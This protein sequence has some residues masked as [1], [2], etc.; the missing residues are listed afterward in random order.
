MSICEHY[1][2]K[3]TRIRLLKQRNLGPSVARNK[4]ID[5]AKGKYIA[6]VD[7]DD[8]VEKDMYSILYCNA[9][10][11]N[12]DIVICGFTRDWPDGKIEENVINFKNEEVIT[13]DI[14]ILKY[15]SKYWMGLKYANYIC[16]KLYSRNLFF[17]H[18]VRFPDDLRFGEDRILHYILLPYINKTIYINRDLYHYVQRLDSAV[19][20]RGNQQNLFSHYIDVYNRTIKI[21]DE[22]GIS[23]NLEVIYPVFMC[24]MIQGAIYTTRQANKSNDYISIMMSNAIKNSEEARKQLKS[25]VYG[26]YVTVYRSMLGLDFKEEFKMRGFALSCLLGRSGFKIWQKIYNFFWG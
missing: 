2:Q 21:W 14:G 22:C 4:G 19:Y 1:A 9:I 15:F 7:S 6:F 11:T 5:I 25:V 24:R 23:R 13:N 3:D 18:N 17:L 12:A 20:T 26:S 16:N 8:Y 10:D